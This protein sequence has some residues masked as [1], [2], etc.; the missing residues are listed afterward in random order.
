V[1]NKKCNAADEKIK[2]SVSTL[3]AFLRKKGLLSV[4]YGC[5]RISKSSRGLFF[6]LQREI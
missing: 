1:E 3:D 5:S 4:Q 2:Q 6:N